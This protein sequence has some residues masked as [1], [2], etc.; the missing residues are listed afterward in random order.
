MTVLIRVAVYLHITHR[1]WT[2]EFEDAYRTWGMRVGEE[3]SMR[4]G[5]HYVILENPDGSW[6]QHVAIDFLTVCDRHRIVTHNPLDN[7]DM[8]QFL[9]SEEFI[10]NAFEADCLGIIQRIYVPVICDDVNLPYR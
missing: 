3:E 9:G 6:L 1:I 2:L 7:R 4:R 8:V 5:T 10:T